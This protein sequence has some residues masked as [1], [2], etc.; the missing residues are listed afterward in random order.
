MRALRPF[1]RGQ[2]WRPLLDAAAP[3]IARLRRQRTSWTCIDDPSNRDT[4][5]ARNQ[6][7]HEILP[8]LQAALAAG[9]GFDPAQRRAQS[10]RR[11]CVARAMAGRVR[12]LC[13]TRPPAV[14][15]PPAGWRS[16]RRCASRC[17]TTGCMRRGLSAP[18]TA[19]RQ[20]IERQCGARAGQ[21]PCIRWAGAELHIWKGRLWALPPA[22]CRSIPTGV[23]TG[24]ANRWPCPMAASCR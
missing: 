14:W 2:L 22:S 13:T 9:G 7:R 15:M 20:Q 1:G 3:T 21:L 4:R 6:L 24:T 18:T 16:S 5:L 11:R 12:R 23:P 19:Q 17:W 8:R 10:R